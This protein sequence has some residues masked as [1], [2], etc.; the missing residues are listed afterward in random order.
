MQVTL[1]FWAS[2]N[3]GLC[4]KKAVCDIVGH[5]IEKINVYG[6]PFYTILLGMVFWK[7]FQ[8]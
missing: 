1:H 4:V 6:M 3:G 2:E 8:G 7:F 5:R